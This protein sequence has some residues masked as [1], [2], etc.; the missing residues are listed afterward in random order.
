M[1]NCDDRLYHSP[2]LNTYMSS[3]IFTW[4]NI[5]WHV[6][7]SLYVFAVWA[8]F[9]SRYLLGLF[10]TGI[11]T[12]CQDVWVI[13]QVWG[14]DGWILASSVLHVYGRDE[15]EV[16]KLTKEERGQYPAILTKQT[17]SIKDLLY[18]F[19][20]NFTRGIQWVVL[21][22]QDGSILPAQVA[23][24]SVLFGSCCLLAEMAI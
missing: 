22:G 20:G 5:S 3:H 17:W 13:D 19:L 6:L 23:N 9:V 18:G 4:N 7:A 8:I 10:M 14:Q 15:I 24:H 16:H 11:L 2:L 1:Y 12:G 21:S